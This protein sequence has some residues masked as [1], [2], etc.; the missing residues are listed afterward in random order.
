MDLLDKLAEA[1][2]QEALENGDFDDL[3]GA[4]R[5]LQLDDDSA[6]PEELRAA[7]RI[8]KNAGFL[9]LALQI[10]REIHE[11]EKLLI[12]IEDTAQR[13][14]AFQ[15]LQ[16]LRARLES[17]HQGRSMPLQSEELYYRKLLEHLER[18]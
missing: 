5:P 6:V 9:P 14:R 8:F 4:G 16:M 3:P 13:S 1:R 11:T 2:I 10:R 7:Y 12:G 18:Q 17:S 15:R